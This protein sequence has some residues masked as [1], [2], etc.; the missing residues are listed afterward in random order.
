MDG[1]AIYFSPFSGPLLPGD[2]W[3]LN[4]NELFSLIEMKV[5]LLQK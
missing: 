5:F 3:L 2:R 1:R 4:R